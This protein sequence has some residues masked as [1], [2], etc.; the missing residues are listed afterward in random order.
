MTWL[1]ACILLHGLTAGFQAREY[2]VFLF[3]L[4]SLWLRSRYNTLRQWPEIATWYRL[5]G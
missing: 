1:L 5:R 4:P 3:V 2:P